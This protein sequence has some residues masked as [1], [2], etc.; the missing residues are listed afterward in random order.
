MIMLASFL[1]V[2]KTQ[3]LKALK[4]DVFDYTPLCTDASSPRNPANIRVNLILLETA[5]IALHLCC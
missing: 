1:K 4:I 5:V 3:R 2:P